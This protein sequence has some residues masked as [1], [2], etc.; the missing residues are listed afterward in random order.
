[1]SVVGDFTIPTT[2]FALDHA[3]S[4]VPEVI[5][6]ADRLA[7]HSPAEVLPFLWGTDGDSETFLHALREDPTISDADIAEE[8]GDEVLY[9]VEW[10]EPVHKLVHEMVDHHA[11][12]L[13]ARAQGDQWTLRLRFS[14]EE[15]VSSFQTFFEERGTEFTV[16]QLYHPTEPRQRAFGLTAEQH[17]TLVAA[18][19][20][21]YFAIPRTTSAEE[22]GEMLGVSGNAV[23]ER[24]RRASEA[25]IRSG[26]TIPED[27]N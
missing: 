5:V 17:E 2:A 12:I 9:R 15:M 23:S 18:V 16:N 19:N 10:S 27:A 20:E 11:A 3:L 26:L 21:G 6:E 4:T 22:L 24:I 25:L 13:E 7:T 8:A 14:D 1:M